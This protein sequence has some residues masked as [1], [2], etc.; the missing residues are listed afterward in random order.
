MRTD[1]RRLLALTLTTTIWGA[2]CDADTAQPGGLEIT[3]A[4]ISLTLAPGASADVEVNIVRIG[5][6][7][8]QVAVHASN[9]PA[10]VTSAPLTVLADAD[11]G[12]LTFTAASTAGGAAATVTVTATASV[13]EAS[14]QLALT[15]TANHAAVA[16]PRTGEGAN[17]ALLDLDTHASARSS[18]LRS[19]ELR[20][21][22]WPARTPSAAGA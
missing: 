22:W 19:R 16:S 20:W 2:G 4:P 6:F 5:T 9:L 3:L 17:L 21:T 8:G 7:D 14:A 1:A 12:T 18:H 13:D 15:V 10:G 11:F